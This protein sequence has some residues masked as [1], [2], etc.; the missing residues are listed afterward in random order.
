MFQLRAK[1]ISNTRIKANY[2]HCAFD[3]P[4]IA[5]EAAPGQ[6][7]NI[8][9]GD[10]TDPLLRRPVSIHAAPFPRIEILYAV[11]GRGT[12][13]LSCKKPGEYLDLIGP[14]GKGFDLSP[15]TSHRQ[16]VIVA[17]GMGAAPLVFLAQRLAY[18]VGC[19]AYRKKLN[20]IRYPLNAIALIGARTKSHIHCQNE[21]KKLCCKVKVATDDGSLGFKG[22]VT[23][24]LQD[25]LRSTMYE[26]RSAIYACG[27]RPML[28]EVARISAEKNIPAQICLEEHMACGIGAC[29]GCVVKTA[30][31]Y[32]RACK[33]GPVFEAGR[34]IF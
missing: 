11:V 12:Q 14:L 17:G 2:F 3:A 23:G 25:V 19:G 26:A 1:V 7:V 21:F 10:A 6:F 5:K 4:R 16:P 15:V 32:K 27:P 20:A 22:R 34:I 9:L 33:D 28:K 31:G 8:R 30:D 13:I 18:S 24:L 29:L